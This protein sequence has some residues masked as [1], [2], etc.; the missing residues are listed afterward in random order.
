MHIKDTNNSSEA[1][2]TFKCESKNN[3]TLEGVQTHE[4]SIMT[5]QFNLRYNV[6][7][8]WWIVELIS[9]RSRWKHDWCSRLISLRLS[10]G[11]VSRSKDFGDAHELICCRLAALQ[12]QLG[13]ADGLQPDILAKKSQSDQFRVSLIPDRSTG[14][15]ALLL[16][17]PPA[18][19]DELTCDAT[20]PR[21]QMIA[22]VQRSD[23]SYTYLHISNA[24]GSAGKALVGFTW[25]NGCF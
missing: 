12:D 6:C 10:Q 21:L 2:N 15:P 22:A 7:R 19:L 16:L 9:L 4:S 24:C 1:S 23:F 13:A 5:L 20:P 11:S 14:A 3:T 17:S 25:V 18:D 8:C